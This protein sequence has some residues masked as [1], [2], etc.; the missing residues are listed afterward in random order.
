MRILH[1][2]ETLAR[3]YG[4]PSKVLPELAKAQAEAGL[5]VEIL[6]TNADQPHGVYHAPGRA[7][8]PDSAVWVNYCPSFPRLLRFSTGVV[9]FLRRNARRF[10][11]FHIHGLY[12]F[13]PSYAGYAARKAGIPYIIRPHGS[14]DPYLFARSSRS[15]PLKRTYERLIDRPNLEAADAI[16]YTTEDERDR[17]AFLKLRPRAFVVPNGLDWAPYDALPARGALRARLGLDGCPLVLFLGRLHHKKGMD[18]LI[19]AFDALRRGMPAARL[20]IVGPEPDGYGA[21]VRKW[22]AQRGLN[23]AVLFAGAMTGTDVLQAY[24]D[25][26]VFVLSSYTE[27]F[28]MSV[29]EAMACGRP[30]VISDQVNIHSDVARAGAG[31]VT[32][33]DSGEVSAALFAL[34]GDEAR[35]RALGEAGR[36]L[37]RGRFTWA[38][39]VRQLQAQYEAVLAAHAR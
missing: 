1:V 35:R 22:V 5:E 11:L 15:L 39:I 4:G 38:A 19:A 36:S 30:V 16:H 10:D 12:R 18:I 27:N 7:R 31:I 28:G 6:T 13:P 21:Q 20:V 34:L 14:L 2:Q 25:A 26:D 9:G 23:D 8:L 29:V 32:R 24:V 37:V 3:N 33:C 17:A